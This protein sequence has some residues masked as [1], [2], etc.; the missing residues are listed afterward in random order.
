MKFFLLTSHISFSVG[1]FCFYQVLISFNNIIEILF[2]QISVLVFFIYFMYLKV[3]HSGAAF[4]F[5]FFLSSHMQQ[6]MIDMF[7]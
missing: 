2:A 5:Y 1:F 6:D 4:L 3:D 7:Y